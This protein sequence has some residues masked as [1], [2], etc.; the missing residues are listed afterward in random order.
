MYIYSYTSAYIRACI[1]THLREFGR[2]SLT[3]EQRTN[4]RAY[5]YTFFI[6]TYENTYAPACIWE[7][8]PYMRAP[9]LPKNQYLKSIVS[10]LTVENAILE[11]VDI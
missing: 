11:P 6:H 7:Q 9:T 3:R 2:S 10:I 5:I 1:H 8:Q 4:I